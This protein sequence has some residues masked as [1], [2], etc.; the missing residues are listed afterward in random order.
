M[1]IRIKQNTE[2]CLV[3]LAAARRLYTI[4]KQASNAYLMLSVVLVSILT[5][6]SIA[7]NSEWA[8]NYLSI[9]K[10][11]ISN[12]VAIT[13]IIVLT[14]DKII[15]ADWIESAKE[16]AA[17]IQEQLDRQLFRFAWN[18][19]LLGS[20]PAPELIAKHGLWL[21]DRKGTKPFQDWYPLTND[22]LP[23]SYQIL[24]C[25]NACLFWDVNLREKTNTALLLLGIIIFTTALVSS[26]L[27]DLSVTS[28][29]T[30]LVALSGPI[31][32]YGYSTYSK[33]K[34]SIDSTKRLLN[35]VSEAITSTEKSHLIEDLHATCEKIQ[36][37]LFLKRKD[38][39]PVPDSLYYILR[40]SDEKAMSYSSKELE[41]NLAERLNNIIAK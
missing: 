8:V 23:L 13:S 27:A 29:V 3:K 2:L 24:I 41:E 21:L 11:D 6:L 7:L 25:Q 33:N 35:C 16:N 1:K 15:L 9:K 10:L 31:A 28:A 26:V 19:P 18:S 34:K 17:K 20:K 36:D 5:F 12:W 30:N 39:W 37:Q 40:N 38:D 14:I 4:S 32:D 22:S